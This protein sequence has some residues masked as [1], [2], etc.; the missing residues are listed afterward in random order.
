MSFEEAEKLALQTLKQVMEEQINATNIEVSLRR[1]AGD[2]S[3]SYRRTAA[4]N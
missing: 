1:R 4:E 3:L 2:S